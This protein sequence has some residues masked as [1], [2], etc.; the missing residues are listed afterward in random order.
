MGTQHQRDKWFAVV[1][2]PVGPGDVC[3]HETRGPL[4]KQDQ[5]TYLWPHRIIGTME[6]QDR[7]NNRYAGLENPWEYQIRGE[8]GTRDQKNIGH[9]IRA[10][11]GT[12]DET[13]SWHT[14]SEEQLTHRTRRTLDTGSEQQQEQTT[15]Q[16]DDTGSEEQLTHRIR[17]TLDTG[18]EQ[19]QVRRTR[20]PWEYRIREKAGYRTRRTLDAE[21][22]QRQVQRN[23][24]KVDIGSEEQLTQDQ[25]TIGHTAPEVF[26]HTGPGGQSYNNASTAQ[27]K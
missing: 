15:R 8:A 14:G 21:S 7:S 19:Q 17:R 3:T 6:T 20:E 25:R 11:T 18:S 9:R 4:A 23:R 27:N 10:T 26:C 13:N 2:E 1:G 12:I 5:R 24:Q 22:E 16:T